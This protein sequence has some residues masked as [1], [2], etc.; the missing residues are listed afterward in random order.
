MWR[1]FYVVSEPARYLHLSYT[2]MS[3]PHS[4][5]TAEALKATITERLQAEHVVGLGEFAR[6]NPV[7]SDRVFL[8]V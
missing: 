5:V 3:A 2:D 1:H 7:F 8:Y 6:D 4:G